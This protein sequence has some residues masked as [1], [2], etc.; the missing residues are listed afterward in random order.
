MEAPL[1]C[2]AYP[3]LKRRESATIPLFAL[4]RDDVLRITE[5]TEVIAELIVEY[6]IGGE[7]RKAST[8]RPIRILDRNAMTWDDD[9]RAA[10][11]VTPRDPTVMRFAKIVAGDLRDQGVQTIDKN[12]RSAIALYTALGLYGMNYVEDP[13]T[14]YAQLSQDHQSVDYLQFPRQSLEVRTGDCD[15]LSLLF[16][17]LLESIGIPTAFITVPG[18]IYLAFKTDTDVRDAVRFFGGREKLIVRADEVWVP[19]EM[20]LVKSGF[21]AGWEAGARQWQ[22]NL[23]EA[24]KLLPLAEAWQTYEPVWFLFP[25]RDIL[26]PG[27]TSLL[28]AYRKELDRFVQGVVGPQIAELRRRI[29]ATQQNA[30]LINRLGILYAS[31]GQY[32]QAVTELEK[33]SGKNPYFPALVNLGNVAYLK[34][35]FNKALTYYAAAGRLNPHDPTALLGLARTQF[36]LSQYEAAR[37]SW[38]RLNEQD[39]RLA[40]RFSYIVST[41]GGTDR[42]SSQELKGVTVWQETD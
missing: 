5:A 17:A 40:A 41:S 14:P 15:D 30:A 22:D 26:V 25:E 13:R 18:H 36:E 9:R 12:V 8:A 37:K 11:F 27:G 34:G 31:I 6:T 16:A 7:P 21:L 3:N 29:S 24:A 19:V 28:N 20:T 4:F 35:D 38:Q 39:N 2:A 23:P 1:E 42:A 33:L 10:A 32:D